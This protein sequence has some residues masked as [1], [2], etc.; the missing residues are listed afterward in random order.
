LDTRRSPPG[1]KV[2]DR[3]VAEINLG[4]EQFPGDWNYEFPSRTSPRN[5][6]AIP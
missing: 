2:S 3:Q 4:R 1:I 6:N 5:G